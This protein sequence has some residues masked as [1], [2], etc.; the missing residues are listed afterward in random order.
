M[1]VGPPLHQAVKMS[2]ESLVQTSRGSKTY[3]SFVTNRFPGLSR[4]YVFFKSCCSYQFVS[5]LK[6]RHQLKLFWSYAI[7]DTFKCSTFFLQKLYRMWPI[8]H[9]YLAMV[10]SGNNYQK[11]NDAFRNEDMKTSLPQQRSRES[12]LTESFLQKQRFWHAVWPQ[13]VASWPWMN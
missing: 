10:N 12:V 2:M 4:P 9:L 1:T 8:E 7:L 11:L 6:S 13:K 3:F 5:Q